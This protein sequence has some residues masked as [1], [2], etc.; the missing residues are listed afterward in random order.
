MLH[1]SSRSGLASAEQIDCM[2]WARQRR[3]LFPKQFYSTARLEFDI[4]CVQLKKILVELTAHS[5]VSP[6][7]KSVRPPSCLPPPNRT[8]LNPLVVDPQPIKR[9]LHKSWGERWAKFGE[10]AAW[11][12]QYMEL[13]IRKSRGN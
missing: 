2:Q 10:I 11:K 13:E 7:N 6:A 9:D 8:F 5:S 3:D 12:R 4:Y 1:L